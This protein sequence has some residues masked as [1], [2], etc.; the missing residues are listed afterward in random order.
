M[1][2]DFCPVL[3][4]IVSSDKE[5][6]VHYAKAALKNVDPF[7]LKRGPSQSVTLS[8]HLCC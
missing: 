1:K 4:I 8:L 5:T 2:R 3:Q 7:P 6:Q